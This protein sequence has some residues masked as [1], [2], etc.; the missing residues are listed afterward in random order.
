MARN[1]LTNTGVSKDLELIEIDSDTP[2]TF[3]NALSAMTDKCGIMLHNGA[4]MRGQVQPAVFMAARDRDGNPVGH[5]A[6]VV[7]SNETSLD[8]VTAFWGMLATDESR[9]GE[10]I[11]LVLGA[12]TM[13]EM[14]RRRRVN[15]FE[16]AIEAGNTSSEKLCTRLGFARSN[17]VVVFAFDPTFNP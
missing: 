7:N 9:R 2:V 10:R 12:M 4:F 8:K 5:A 17:K 14:N 13:I 15:E 3:L 1:V 16:T 11:A 6:S